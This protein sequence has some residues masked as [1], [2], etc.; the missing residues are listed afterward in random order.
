MRLCS[1][2]STFR[3]MR[4]LGSPGRWSS[5]TTTETRGAAWAIVSTHVLMTAM[6]SSHSPSTLV[7]MALVSLG[8]PLA[9]T[10]RT[11]SATRSPTDSPVPIGVM[12]NAAS[13]LNIVPPEDLG[14]QRPP[15]SVLADVHDLASL[16]EAMTSPS[17]EDAA[18]EE[19]H[20]VIQPIMAF[21]EKVIG[22]Y[23]PRPIQRVPAHSGTDLCLSSF[24]GGSASRN[25][26]FSF[27]L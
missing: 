27:I 5:F 12:E 22:H 4:P 25:S 20:G 15:T 7:N 16:Q 23:H 18:A 2:D 10:M 6:I 14:R 11:V 3:R 21:I 13:M 17:P 1:T 9:R 26:F 19:R 8:R 24:L